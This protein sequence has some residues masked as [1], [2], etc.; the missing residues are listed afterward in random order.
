MATGR[1]IRFREEVSPNIEF[2]LQSYSNTQD[3]IQFIDTKV[4]AYVALIGILASLLVGSLVHVLTELAGK[5]GRVLTY[6][7]LIALGVLSLV[8]LYQLVQVFYRAYEV[9]LPRHGPAL[10]EKGGAVGL[11]SASDIS[12]YLSDHTLGEYA[13]AVDQMTELDL[14]E[15]LA[16]EAAKLSGIACVKLR[17][18]EMATNACKWAV[19]TWALLLV[20]VVVLEVLLPHLA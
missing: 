6:A 14:I 12:E 5:S 20:A 9:L 18:L 2:L 13:R 3:V 11:F 8:F 7:L 19:L 1:D 16:Y 4:G 15:E 10:I 17:H